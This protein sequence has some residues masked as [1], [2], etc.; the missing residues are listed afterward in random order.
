MIAT[1]LSVESQFIVYDPG[2][3]HLE[4]YYQVLRITAAQYQETIRGNLSFGTAVT[5][6]FFYPDRL[7]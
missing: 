4:A 2:V 6:P 7:D 5:C 1:T 3:L